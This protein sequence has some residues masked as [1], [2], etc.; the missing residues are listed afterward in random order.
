MSD[1]RQWPVKKRLKN[2]LI[3]WFIRWLVDF[4]RW[5]PRSAAVALMGRL[6][7]LALHLIPSARRV[8]LHQLQLAY[9]DS[10]T[11]AEIERMAREVFVNLGR[12]AA[13]AIRLPVLVRQGLDQF[14]QCRG[15]EHLDR[16]LACGRGVIILTGHIGSWELLAAYLVHCGYPLAVVGA[17]LYDPRLNKMLVEAR[18]QAG[19]HNIARGPRGTREMLRWLRKGGVL[20]I[21]IDQDTEVEGVFVDF[22]GRPAH[23]PVGP[24]I[25]AQKTGAAIVPLAIHRQPDGTHLAEIRPP[26][27]LQSTGDMMADR[28]EN[29]R[30]C[31]KAV[32]AFI[33][34]HPTQWVWMHERWRRQP[35]EKMS[36][37]L[38][39]W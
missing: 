39:P 37:A 28:L 3:Y 31:S 22:Y 25:L 32:E 38:R 23:T 29:V 5:L 30:R 34:E 24:V 21:L 13:D 17:E 4:V 9:G 11:A 27:P 6:G 26:I 7:W 10:K 12:N 33:R 8:T 18:E 14:V 16:A 35:T 20:G 36:S 19:Y 15:A 1:P 2:S